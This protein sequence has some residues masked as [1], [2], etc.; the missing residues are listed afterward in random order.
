MWQILLVIAVLILSALIFAVAFII[1]AAG[2]LAQ[3]ALQ[4]ML[5]FGVFVSVWSAVFFWLIYYI[6]AG[7]AFFRRRFARAFALTLLPFVGLYVLF[8]VQDLV[9]KGILDAGTS[10]TLDVYRC[11]SW[12]IPGLFMLVSYSEDF[13]RIARRYVT[14]ERIISAM[15]SMRWYGGRL[16]YVP[17]AI[18]LW[19]DWGIIAGYAWA[20]SAS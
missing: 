17:L 19:V 6:F 8:V 2:M 5:D 10:W 7:L 12:V 13:A 11:T 20:Q 14:E 15:D 1:I 4:P 9:L 16:W 18:G 3:A